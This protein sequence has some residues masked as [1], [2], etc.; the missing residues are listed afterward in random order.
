[1]PG[2]VVSCLFH[3][4]QIFIL[5]VLLTIGA[6]YAR[7]HHH[8]DDA[9]YPQ[10]RQQDSLKW[11]KPKKIPA[12][13]ICLKC[14]QEFLEQKLKDAGGLVKGY[15]ARNFTEAQKNFQDWFGIQPKYT[16]HILRAASGWTKWLIKE[17]VQQLSS[18]IKSKN[19]YI[20]QKFGKRATG[21]CVAKGSLT[22]SGNYRMCKECSATT[23]LPS[24]K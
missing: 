19:R 9:R 10:H 11:I 16:T 7:F 13:S 2:C 5:P 8:V 15:V 20:I 6:V 3:L 4:L 18:L 14:T 22:A 24:D 21:K 12:S 1:M 17:T 23:V